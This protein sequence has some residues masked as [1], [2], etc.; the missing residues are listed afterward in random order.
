VVQG[1]S[2]R[3]CHVVSSHLFVADSLVRIEP[4]IE[5]HRENLRPVVAGRDSQQSARI[6]DRI[7]QR[8]LG[9]PRA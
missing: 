4:E 2:P 9:V 1:H 5:Q 3:E 6:L 8:A 7:D